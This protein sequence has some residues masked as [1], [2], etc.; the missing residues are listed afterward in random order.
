VGSPSA[1]AGART[2]QACLLLYTVVFL[3]V[4]TPV[5][6]LLWGVRSAGFA[7]H[8]HHF[9]GLCGLRHLLAGCVAVVPILGP[10]SR[11]ALPGRRKVAGMHALA[12]TV[13]ATL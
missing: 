4:Y 6:A 9:A 2:C 8:V 10:R 1:S 12:C 7:A 13:L 5:G 3:Y 11:G